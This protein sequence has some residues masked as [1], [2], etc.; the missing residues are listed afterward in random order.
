MQQV[1][2]CP[3]CGVEVQPHWDRCEACGYSHHD[4][5]PAAESR[6]ASPGFFDA[7]PPGDA[8]APGPI[9]G[10]GAADAGDAIALSGPT[11]SAPPPPPPPPP[12]GGPAFESAPYEAPAYEAPA[13]E[14]P[15]Y[16]APAYDA[17]TDDHAPPPPPPPPPPIDG[18]PPVPPSFAEPPPVDPGPTDAA[19]PLSAWEQ[20]TPVAP[21]A[22]AAREPED[23]DESDGAGRSKRFGR[24]PKR[25]TAAQGAKTSSSFELNKLVVGIAAVL[26]LLV[27]AW[28]ANTLLKSDD[29]VLD[30][31]PPGSTI[32]PLGA[33]ATTTTPLTTPDGVTIV[34]P[35]PTT[36]TTSRARDCD[37][38]SSIYST[39]GKGYRPCGAGFQVDLPGRADIKSSTA[40]TDLGPV[41]WTLLS[42]TDSGQDPA[43]RSIVVFGQ[44]PR[45]VAP[46]ETTGVLESLIATV[47]ATPGGETTF[48]DLPARTFTG[49]DANGDSYQGI[50][51]VNG[52]RAFALATRTQGSP[53]AALDALEG[54]FAFV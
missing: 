15:A 22:P 47:G 40:E 43:V 9:G 19:D 4:E 31:K 6:P 3:R 26:A 49:T 11:T 27:F 54:S 33:I 35:A 34:P 1:P 10:S 52:A 50:A 17:P 44:L 53:R 46:E 45:E 25:V 8:P 28:Q 32:P 21:R 18:P 37:S 23:A 51:F 16:E 2:E 42:S 41:T 30:A 48:Q 39:D 13:Y 24:A 20:P 5:E 36:S 7:P 12:P 38:I 14:P 29:V